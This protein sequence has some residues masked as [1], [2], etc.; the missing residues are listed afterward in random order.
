MHQRISIHAPH[1]GSDGPFFR[2][3]TSPLI[4]IHAPHAGSDIDSV[5]LHELK[6]AFQ[7]TL[8][9]RGATPGNGFSTKSV[10]FQSTLPM[11][12]A[13]MMEYPNECI[14]V[15]QSTLPMRDNL[16]GCSVTVTPDFNPRSPCGERH[17]LMDKVTYWRE[18]SIHAPHAGSDRGLETGGRRCSDFNPR[19]PCG[20]RH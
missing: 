13:T 11:R 4:S 15:F 5:F 8:P 19:S 12:G 20:E 16:S 17:Q 9:M 7:S 6:Q 3:T 2:C 1:A 10:T 14:Y 18:I